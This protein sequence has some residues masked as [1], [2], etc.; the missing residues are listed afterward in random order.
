MPASHCKHSMAGRFTFD[1][2]DKLHIQPGNGFLEALTLDKVTTYLTG[3]KEITPKGF[4]DP[5]GH[6]Q[7]VDVIICATGFDTSWVPRFPI[8]ANGVNL[9]DVQAKRPISYLSLAVPQS[10][11]FS[12]FPPSSFLTLITANDQ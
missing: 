11:T 9:Q 7:E 5:D 10:Q 12:F 2:T 8:V 6:E 1:T 3:V 4:L